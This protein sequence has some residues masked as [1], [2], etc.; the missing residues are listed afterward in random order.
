[1]KISIGSKIIDGPFGGGNEF[2]KILLI[3]LKIV[4]IL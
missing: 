3:I 2:L 4:D 1:M